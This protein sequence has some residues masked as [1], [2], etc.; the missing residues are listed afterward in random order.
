MIEVNKKRRKIIDGRK[1]ILIAKKFG[2]EKTNETNIR[3]A[4]NRNFFDATFS[5]LIVSK[6]TG[7]R[8]DFGFLT[9]FSTQARGFS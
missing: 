4:L 8:F 9:T 1:E 3:L 2:E 7:R 5:K 6:P